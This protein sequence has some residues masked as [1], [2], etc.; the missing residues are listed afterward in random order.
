MW[1]RYMH[2]THSLNP[3]SSSSMSKPTKQ[4]TANKLLKDLHLLQ[5]TCSHEKTLE[6]STRK[7]EY[8]NTAEIYLWWRAA[9]AHDGFLE[10]QYAKLSN[11]ELRSVEYGYN[12]R[13]VLILAYGKNMPDAVIS[14]KSR[15]LNKVHEH[16]EKDPHHFKIDGVAKLANFIDTSGGFDGLL[17]DRIVPTEAIEKEQEVEAGKYAHHLSYEPLYAKSRKIIYLRVNDAQRINALKAEAYEYF[18][19]TAQGIATKISPPLRKNKHNYS[20]VL[21]QSN[22]T[23]YTVLDASIEQEAIDAAVVNAYCKRYS[24][25][26][27]SLRAI[28]ETIRT[29]T[30]SKAMLRHE[31]RLDTNTVEKNSD[32]KSISG[33]RR[34]MYCK[35]TEQF[36]LSPI[37]GSLGVV[38]L[39]TPTEPVFKK[40]RKDIFMP[41]RNRQVIEHRL[42]VP[43]DF[44]LYR[45][46]KT[47]TFPE[48][49]SN[50]LVGYMIRL[51]NKADPTDFTFNDFWTFASTVDQYTQLT[52][53]STAHS[54]RATLKTKIPAHELRKLATQIVGAWMDDAGSGINQEKFQSIQMVISS[55]GIKFEFDHAREGKFRVSTNI[56]FDKPIKLDK[57][58]KQIF[59]S[60]DIAPVLGS[61][62]ALE[63]VGNVEL[64]GDATALALNFSTSAAAFTICV[65]T[66]N[67]KMQRQSDALSNYAP[68]VDYGGT[69]TKP[70][71][72]LTFDA[73]Y[74]AE[75]SNLAKIGELTDSMIDEAA[76]QDGQDDYEEIIGDLHDYEMTSS[77]ELD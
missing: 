72:S 24:A 55:T 36:I 7:L 68:E 49:N 61:F 67:T 57:P 25:L 41:I 54:K 10:A 23:N 29:Q 19:T 69:K 13:Y 73:A 35:N 59:L 31:K 26:P 47:D 14:R 62:E 70:N 77:L 30:L 2:L 32:G 20:L 42:L 6:V 1:D 34:L 28:Y 75:I 33:K 60:H 27:N 56:T 66:C 16:Y 74:Y 58:F 11:R 43:N 9:Y 37:G 4:P 40:V 12:Y 3:N 48:Y 52:Y 65:P 51:D 64:T 44:N 53:D 5:Q 50:G 76:L 45:A 38:T 18:T 15:V 46:S 21:A 22:E 71:Q 8:K 39:V 17:K 63:V